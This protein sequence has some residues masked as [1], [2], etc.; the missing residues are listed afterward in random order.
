MTVG[1]PFGGVVKT[2]AVPVRRSGAAAWR[3]VATVSRLVGGVLST[4]PLPGSRSVTIHLCGPPGGS[5]RGGTDGPPLPPVRPCSEW[6]LPSHPDRSGCW[7]ALTAPFHPCLCRFPGHRRFVLCGTFLRVAPTGI[8]PAPCPAEPRPSSTRS[9]PRR[10][11][12][13]R[14]HPA[15]SPSPHSLA[16]A[17]RKR[18]AIACPRDASQFSTQLTPRHQRPLGR[19]EAQVRIS[20]WQRRPGALARRPSMVSSVV[21]RASAKAT[22]AES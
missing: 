14:G 21:C 22:Y 4:G 7:C 8:S 5:L 20:T 11:A 18:K 6:G 17:T 2:R 16:A 15:D 13:S 3:L 12:P 9:P 10:P 1:Q 19:F